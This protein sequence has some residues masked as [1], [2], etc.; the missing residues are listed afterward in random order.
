MGHR[1]WSCRRGRDRPANRL[2]FLAAQ[3]RKILDELRALRDVMQ[4]TAAIVMRQ[5]SSLSAIVEQLRAMI[6]QHQ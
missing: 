2:D 3:N 1:R 5:D 6:Q 4:V